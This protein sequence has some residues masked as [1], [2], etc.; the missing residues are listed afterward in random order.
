MSTMAENVIAAGA[1]NR[2]PMLEK[3]QYNSWQSRMK[4]YIR[5]KE[6][7]K[8]L[9]DS[10]LNGPFKYGTVDV[11][12]TPTTTAYMRERT[13]EDLTEKEKIHD[14]IAS[15]NKAMAFI[16]TTFT[17][18]Y[19][20]TNNQ[21]CTSSNPRNHATIQDG[22]VT[23]QNVQGRQSYGYANSD[24]RI[25]VVGVNRSVGST[26]TSQTKIIRCYNFQKAVLDEEQ[27]DFLADNRDAVTKGQAP[28]ARV[29]LM[30]KLYAYYSDVLSEVPSHDI[31][32]QNNVFDTHVQ[33]LQ[34]SEQPPFIDDS[35]IESM[36]D[37]HITS[38]DQY[39]KES[40][41]ETVQDTTSL[42]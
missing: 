17:S 24:S 6:H 9:L 10:V 27:M 36:S 16:S 19:L 25:N 18:R 34:Y 33:E 22:R 38:Y 30:A 1:D 2:P 29:V 11:P 39:L 5:G 26:T 28:S 32:L 42:V 21:F 14:P 41:N 23:V 8:D 7:G 37:S 13:Y 20:P 12:A 40:E 31:N 3:S 35:N 4:L 15:L